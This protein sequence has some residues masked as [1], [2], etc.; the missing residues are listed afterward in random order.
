MWPLG[1]SGGASVGKGG[2]SDT[3]SQVLQSCSPYQ[4]RLRVGILAPTSKY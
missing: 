2:E 4:C 1:E 3:E